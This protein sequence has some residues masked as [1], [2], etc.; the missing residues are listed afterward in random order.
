LVESDIDKEK[1]KEEDH[2]ILGY[3]TIV[4]ESA[5]LTATG[6]ILFGFLL[7]ISINTPE[8]F[9]S[10]NKITLLIALY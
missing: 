8:D 10:I 4:R 6:G 5:L 3:D 2:L 1:Q 7:D 9:S